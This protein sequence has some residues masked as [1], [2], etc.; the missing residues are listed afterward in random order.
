M[1]L[2]ELERNKD[3]RELQF[4][5]N[6]IGHFAL[7]LGLH[8]WLKTANGARVVSVSSTGSLWSPILW[9]DPDF[10]FIPY[11]PF[12]AYGQSKTACILVSG[13]IGRKWS[14]DNI[15][16]NSLNPGAIATNLQ[17]HTGGLK[18][19]EPYRKTPQQGAATSVLLA[20]DFR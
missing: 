8:P 6:F 9:D 18:T 15:A 10:R 2:P 19:P 11:H 1:A 20:V 4:A 16:S 3:G 13:G 17:R 7:T 14:V 12:V 5:T